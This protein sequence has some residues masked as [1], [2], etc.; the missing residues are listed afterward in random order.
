MH[1]LGLRFYVGGK[2]YFGTDRMFFVERALGMVGAEPERLV[3]APTENRAAK[4]TFYFD[5]SSPWSF[6][7]YMRLENMLASVAPVNVNVEWVPILLGALFKQIGTPMVSLKTLYYFTIRITI[8]FP[9]H[10]VY[11]LTPL[12]IGP[13]CCNE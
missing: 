3:T 10:Y 5:Y 1:T 6:I 13:S 8:S 12:Y 7:G 4:L 2:F 9:H 11:V